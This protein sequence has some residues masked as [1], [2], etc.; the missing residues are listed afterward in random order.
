MFIFEWLRQGIM[1]NIRLNMKISF[2]LSATMF[3]FIVDA[4]SPSL[5]HDIL[6]G[7]ESSFPSNLSAINDIAIFTARNN[8]SNYE[9]WRT[10]GTAI[11]TNLLTELNPDTFL[12]AMPEGFVKLNDAFYFAANDGTHGFE[13][14]RTDGTSQGTELVADILP[15][16]YSSY[17]AELTVFNSSLYFRAFT[18]DYG[19]ELWI[20]GG[21]AETTHIVADLA[22]GALSFYP[23]YL[24]AGGSGIYFSR[25]NNQGVYFS[26]GTSDGT[27]A[28]STDVIVGQL[29]AP[30]FAEFEGDVYFRGKDPIGPGFTGTQLWRIH[31]F[32]V[33]R[34]TAIFN[35]TSDFNP[36]HLVSCG[37]LL[38]FFGEEY[39]Y[40]R[41]LWACDGQTA[42]MVRDIVN[43]VED[44]VV[45]PYLTA[46]EG[47]VFFA[48]Y[49]ADFGL[50]PW[51]S[52]GTS[53]G[54]HILQDICPGIAGSFPISP[55]ILNEYLF[56]TADNGLGEQIWKLNQPDIP[57]VLFS[58]LT[59]A[60][61]NSSEITYIN[62]LYVFKGSSESC[63]SELWVLDEALLAQ[64]FEPQALNEIKLWPNPAEEYIEVDFPRKVGS[65][66]EF[67]MLDMNGNVLFRCNFR[68]QQHFPL[69][70]LEL[71]PG[72]YL[73]QIQNHEVSETRRIILK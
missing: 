72:E 32:E 55:K 18:E 49:T 29:D 45:S 8:T 62:N 73:I 40:G 54:T 43:G 66:Y 63:G 47:K 30:Y 69:H 11:G 20:S 70:N 21:T 53:Q 27:V 42:F 71:A 44:G 33:E 26:D 52:D 24:Y 22:E 57:P 3:P 6:P 67:N 25:S 61:A 46:F 31:G 9:L 38:Y 17:P 39:P 35:E 5:L 2:L 60:F 37:N 36:T 15:G 14:W 34:L 64:K 16:A 59:D 50:E 51:I 12:G 10:D 13:L 19:S 23:Q 48:A 7:P 58:N 56:F 4:Q 41:E 1:S 28:L 68:D 65:L